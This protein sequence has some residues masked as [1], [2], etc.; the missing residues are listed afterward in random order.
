[1]MIHITMKDGE[2][3]EPPTYK[4][5]WVALWRVGFTDPCNE[6]DGLTQA[7]KPPK[8]LHVWNMYCKQHTDDGKL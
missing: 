1:M 6:F 7:P 3:G 4:K 2:T 8:A 5:W